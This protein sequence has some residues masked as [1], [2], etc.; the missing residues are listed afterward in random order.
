MLFQHWTQFWD[1]SF[2]STSQNPKNLRHVLNFI[3]SHKS[4]AV[5]IGLLTKFLSLFLDFCILATC[6]VHRK[7]V[8]YS[9]RPG[10]KSQQRDRLFWMSFP[11][12]FSGPPH[13]FRDRTSVRPRPLP[14]TDYS[15]DC[16]DIRS[17]RVRVSNSIVK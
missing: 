8:L 15:I 2:I 7:P 5:P 17:C 4:D 3:F 1:N 16:S 14:S 6:P 11:W 12:I 9:R 13:K 10:F